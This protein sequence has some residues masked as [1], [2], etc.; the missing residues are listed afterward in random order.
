MKGRTNLSLAFSVLFCL[1]SNSVFAQP[2]WT[3]DPFGKEK[4]PEQYEEKK[5][6]SEKTADKKFTPFRRFVQNNI[7]HY[8]FYFNANNKLKAVLERAKLA[9]KD[10]YSQL[11]SFYPYTLENTAA[12]KV[13][14]DSV[15]YKSTGGILLHDLRSDWV[16]NL[17]LL[18]GKS[19]YFMQELDSAALTFQFINYNLFPRK[20]NEDDN[21]IVGSTNNNAASGVL[22]I[23]D[24]EKRNVIQKTFTLPP[25][26]NDALVW[27]ARTFTEQEKF[28]DAAGLINIL[29]N[30]PNLPRRLQNDLEEVT[31]YWFFKQKAF[32]SAAIH[33]E[34][35]ISNADNKTDKSRW[36][37][38]LAQLFE[39]SGDFSK[40]S[41]YYAKAAKHTTDPVMDIYAHLN[42]AKMLRNAGNAKEL[43]NSIAILLKMARKDKYESYRY[44][45]Y[46]SAGQLSLQ[47]PDTLNGITYFGKSLTYNESNA[48]FKNKAHLQL[49]KI[50]YAQRQYKDAANHYD[51]LDLAEPALKEDSADIA[52]RKET[53]HKVVVQLSIIEKEDSLQMIA[54]MPPAERDAFVKKIA[55]KYRKE[56][57]VK[58]EDN[59]AGN[60]LITDFK[61]GKGNEPADL[62]DASSSKGEWYFYNASMKSRGFNEFK[63]KWGKRDN[64][65]NWR[66]KS[67]MEKGKNM[68]ANIDLDDPLNSVPASGD[69]ATAKPVE[70]SYDALMAD[71]PTTPERIDSSNNSIASALITLAQLFENELKDYQQAVY[72]YDIYLQ[73][74]PKMTS[75][76]EAY[77]GLYHCYSKL[78]D[79]PKAAYYKNLLNTEYAESRFA[80]MISNPASL[81][82]DKNNPE[83]EKRYESIY[84]LYIEGNFDSASTEKKKADSLYGN[85]YWTPQLLF[86]EAVHHISLREDSLAIAVLSDI[87]SL[88]PKSPLKEKAITLIDVLH[89]RN[90]IEAYLTNL[91]VTRYAE[92]EKIIFSDEKPKEAMRPVLTSPASNKI[93]APKTI[94]VMKDSAI[95]LPPSMVSGEFKWQA[96]KPHHVIM[97]FDKVDAVYINESKNAF[98]RFNREKNFSKVTITRDVLDAQRALLVFVS[99]VNEEEA[100]AY[101]EKIKKAAPSE[102]SWLQPSKY[103]FLVI[104]D[105]NLQLLK[106]NKDIN[107]YKV[108]LNNLYPGKF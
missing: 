76:A 100:M 11:L 24:K 84:S 27:L 40:A 90:E 82:P 32:D 53:L 92:D 81:Q 93:G 14:L 67:A 6:G 75:N 58:E 97:I 29:Q 31:A 94:T 88:F 13:E 10:D 59:F 85:H 79:E 108:I 20:K 3:L 51:S 60:T 72:T 57:G 103:S 104:S 71:I 87:I 96:G 101:Y 8:N 34:K 73:R 99:F 91:E 77:L 61:N 69:S 37:Y 102:V 9:Q 47:K 95:K 17:Y 15:I 45:I 70:Y 16:D 98:T 22:S 43:D 19:Y 21:R 48:P 65:D 2:T 83:V 46:H 54:A 89:R 63:S 39:V 66:R 52:D 18:I 86:I 78:G 5:L 105:D 30:D 36:Q 68:N 23:A 74:F 64:I 56:K 62:F 107:A 44:I 42:D 25:S 12:Q 26:R 80:K 7:T 41:D 49:G 28:G 38:L 33:L 55:K 1:I 50:A 106:S 35:G 4:K